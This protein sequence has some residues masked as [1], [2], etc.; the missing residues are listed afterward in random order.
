MIK[1]FLDYHISQ[2]PNNGTIKGITLF[3]SDRMKFISVV[4]LKK[5]STKNILKNSFGNYQKSSTSVYRM[6]DF[7]SMNACTDYPEKSISLLDKFYWGH[8]FMYFANSIF[9]TYFRHAVIRSYDDQ[10]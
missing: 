10:D 4:G 7:H 5:K 6:S 9:H 8:D 3:C 1:Y 2:T